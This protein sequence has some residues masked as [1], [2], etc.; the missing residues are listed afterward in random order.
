[1]HADLDIVEGI[2]VHQQH[3]KHW[4]QVLHERRL[5]QLR[6]QVQAGRRQGQP[7]PGE[8]IM[9]EEVGTREEVLGEEPGAD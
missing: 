3:L 7:H 8:G 2:A 5:P 6:R 9:H 1:M 4:H